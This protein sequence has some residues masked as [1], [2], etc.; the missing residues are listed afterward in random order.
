MQEQFARL[1]SLELAESKTLL[2]A[3]HTVASSMDS[4]TVKG[5]KFFHHENLFVTIVSF[6]NEMATKT[7]I[8]YFVHFNE[9]QPAL[10]EAMIFSH[11]HSHLLDTLFIWRA[12]KASSNIENEFHI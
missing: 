9:N 8:V 10:S 6:E 12:P 5:T 11:P 2:S 3:E 7:E 1:K 4:A